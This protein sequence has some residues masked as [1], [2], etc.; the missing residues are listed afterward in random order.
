MKNRTFLLSSICLWVLSA[1]LC[2]EDWPSWGKDHSR[3]MVSSE[4]GIT[5]EFTPGELNEDESVDLGTAQNVKWVAKLG[6]QAYGNVTIG[7]GKV[8]VGTNN[9]TMRDPKKK[10]DRG[11]VMCFNEADGSFAW[12]LVIPKLG[13]GKVSDWEYIGVCSSP[14]IEEGKAYV[15]TNR[16]EVVCLD[17]DGMQDGNDGPYQD[18]QS[19]VRPKGSLDLL[20]AEIDADIIWRYDM[21]DELGVF[22]HNVTSSSALIVGDHLYVATSNGVDWSHTNIPSPLS[23]SWIALDKKTGELIGEDGSGASKHAL[24]A[25]WSSL[26]YGKI[27]DQEILFWGGTDGFLYAYPNETKPDEEGFNLFVPLWKVDCNEPAYRVDEEGRKIPYATPPG[28]SELIATPVLYQDKI[29]CS[30]GQDPEHGDGVGRLSCIDAKTGQVI[31]KNTEIGRT[32]STPSVADGLVYQAEYAG[33]L[34]CL[35]ADTGEVYWTYDSYS[36]I[37]GSTLLVDGKVLLGNEDGDLLIFEHGKEF[38]EPRAINLGAP[39]YSSPVV[40]NQ[41]LYVSTQTH[42]Y[43]VGK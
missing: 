27:E 11:I 20:N 38:S 24:H 2:G 17:L 29:Y 19:Y 34:H 15:V 7:E 39:I 1:L 5:F 35:D 28:P 21:R 22:P 12:Q 9:E 32:I 14:A 8:L 6:S 36:R 4:T 26:A 3:N 40:A 13:A 43:A 37:W 41:T 18:E 31:W 10:G 42:L 23:P 25:A 16:C 33:I 30:I